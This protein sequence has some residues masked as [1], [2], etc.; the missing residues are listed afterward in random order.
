MIGE[1]LQ[2]LKEG[3][4]EKSLQIDMQL[5]EDILLLA[6]REMLQF[7]HRNLL[8][9]AVKFSLTTG[10]IYIFA[11]KQNGTLTVSFKDEGKGIQ[12]EVLARIFEYQDI[13]NNN[14]GAGLALIICKDFMDKMNGTIQAVNNPDKGCTFSYT[15]PVIKH[16]TP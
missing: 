11:T 7:V 12:P 5:P 8:H 3:C 13:P 9:N 1:A 15:L 16:Q 10:T 6:D 14:G 2:A 4:E